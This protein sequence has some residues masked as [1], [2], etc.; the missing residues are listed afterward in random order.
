[1]M[2][3]NGFLDGGGVAGAGGADM[4]GMNGLTGGGGGGVVAASE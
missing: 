4:F 3:P 2:R 1:M